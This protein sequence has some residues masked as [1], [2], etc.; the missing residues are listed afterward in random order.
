MTKKLLKYFGWFCLFCILLIG[1]IFITEIL[2]PARNQ[3]QPTKPS[4]EFHVMPQK[5]FGEALI[6]TREQPHPTKPTLISHLYIPV[7]STL[8]FTPDG[9]QLLGLH[10][11]RGISEINRWDVSN[12]KEL[13]PIQNRHM[14]LLTDDGRFYM[15]YDIVK[16]L[17]ITKRLTNQRLHRTSD[18]TVVASLPNNIKDRHLIKIIGDEH[19]FAVY[20]SS[21]VTDETFP[22]SYHSLGVKRRYYLW[23]IQ[24][25]KFI[26]TTP[27]ITT[28]YD[29]EDDTPDVAYSDDGTK[30]L[31]LW[32]TYTRTT[33][34]KTITVTKNFIH[35]FDP[36]YRQKPKDALLLNE[37][38]GNT[39]ALPFPEK[40]LDFLFA[41]ENPVLSKD[42]KYY[43][44]VSTSIPY[45]WSENGKD[46]TIWC[47]DLVHRILKWKYYGDKQFPD[48][49]T[50]SP[51]GTMLAA[52]GSDN[53]YRHNGVGFLNVIDVKTGKLLHTFTEQTMSEQIRDRT[54]IYL[55]KKLLY[56]PFV[57]K[58][59]PKFSFAMQSPPAPGNSGSIKSLSWSPDN[60]TLAAS[61]EDGAVKL[62]HVK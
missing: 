4:L 36:D 7:I 1:K 2:L 34:D 49:L 20:C 13:S 38:N 52:S 51:D 17:D 5:V 12:G 8:A 28:L 50:F 10:Y 46:G 53:N 3:P 41:W 23:D 15:K 6:P 19:P 29:F 16:D 21:E 14:R 31:S 30:V 22:I 39:I 40:K 18:Q 42:Q 11:P 58:K 56:A 61:Y 9:K 47:Y 43:A 57:D 32:P 25:K 26:S 54:R 55:L 48:L 44:T 62:W 35:W 45:G 27:H 37:L 60:K 59:F 33:D 24:A